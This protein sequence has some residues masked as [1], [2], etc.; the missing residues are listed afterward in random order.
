MGTKF[1]LAKDIRRVTSDGRL[2]TVTGTASKGVLRLTAQINGRTVRE[3]TCWA[4]FTQE[5]A[6]QQVEQLARLVEPLAKEIPAARRSGPAYT[7]AV[8]FGAAS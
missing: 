7:G 4:C 1:I 8:T 2:V 6:D 5:R 3:E